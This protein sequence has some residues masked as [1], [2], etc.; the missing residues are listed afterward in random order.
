[1]HMGHYVAINLH[2]TLLSKH[3]D[4]APRFKELTRFP[5]VMALAVGN[6]AVVFDEEEGTRAGVELGA[7]YFGA[8]L[9]NTSKCLFSFAVVLAAFFF[10]L[11]ER[12][13]SCC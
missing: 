1:M 7:R 3:F 8:D 5:N 13:R 12:S 2:Q 11:V 10:F 4:C 9:G 6:K